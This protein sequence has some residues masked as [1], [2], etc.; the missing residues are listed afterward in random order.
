M[1]MQS[2]K[3]LA[4]FLGFSM[5]ATA[6]SAQSPSTWTSLS[7]LPEPQVEAGAALLDGRI[8]IIGGW[9]DEAGPWNKTQVYDTAKNTWS[10]GVPAPE[11]VHHN[12][13]VALDGKLWLVGGFKRK[14]G[15]REPIAN[16]WVFDPSVGVWQERAPMPSPRGAAVTAAVGGLIYVAGGER[17]RPPGVPVPKGAHPVYEPIAD[18]LAYDPKTAAWTSLPP[19]KTA[20]DHAVGG[21]M[22]GR[23][24]VIGG[25]DRPVYDLNVIEE[26][27]PPAG[28]WT[29][30]APM[31][32]GRSGGNGAAS[33][34]KFFVFGGEGNNAVASGIFPQAEA[35]DPVAD[36]WTQY[37]DMPLPRHSL[38][39]VAHGGRLY[40]PSGAV[41]RGGVDI[42]PLFDAFEPR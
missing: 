37:A 27:N 2:L 34:G 12:G 3:G 25:R 17:R 22:N 20:R 7:P 9:R 24:Y 39:T 28:S 30:R 13:V 1:Q 8:Y 29:T 26:F 32:S 38:A 19:M 42:T 4:F 10:E 6:T 41:K 36:R 14:F 23:L 40:L 15:D 18:L 33:G 16:L 21:E 11:A 35:Y 31:P 5:I